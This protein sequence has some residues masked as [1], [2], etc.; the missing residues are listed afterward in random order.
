[1]PAPADGAASRRE[2]GLWPRRRQARPAI[3]HPGSGPAGIRHPWAWQL[4]RHGP[5]ALRRANRL[6][7]T[8]RTLRARNP[9]RRPAAHRAYRPGPGGRTR[10]LHAAPRSRHRTTRSTR[11]TAV[12][13]PERDAPFALLAGERLTLELP[14]PGLRSY[15]AVR[16]G[17]AVAPQHWAAAP[18]TPCPGWAPNHSGQEPSCPWEPPTGQHCG[19]PRNLTP[20]GPAS[21]HRV[22]A[23]SRSPA[24]LVQHGN[25]GAVLVPRSGC[26]PPVQPDWPAPGRRAAAPRLGTA[27]WPAKAL[28]AELSRSPRKDSRCSFSPIIR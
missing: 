9:P 28:S 10:R 16:G 22:P 5:G 19:P 3:H 1:M 14:L 21:C 12:R 18:P 4:R 7:G 8:R 27:N 15:L 2:A 17:L 13:H 25:R 23:D 20:P 26:H 6:V 11:A 24:G